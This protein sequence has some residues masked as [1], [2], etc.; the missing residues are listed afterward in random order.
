MLDK[1][2][3]SRLEKNYPGYLQSLIDEKEFT[4][5]EL[6]SGLKKPETWEMLEQ[7]VQCFLRH[8][9]K[10]GGYGWTVCWED[11]N[12]KKFGKQ[13][14]PVNIV[15]TSESDFLALVRKE[16][17]TIAFKEQLLALVAWNPEIRS[18]LS[19]RPAKVLELGADW[20]GICAVIDYL[21]K[22]ELHVHYLRSLPVPV[23]TK[24]I[25]RHQATI[26]PLV[27]H[28]HPGICKQASNNLEVA[29]GLRQKSFLFPVRWLDKS[30]Q[31][32]LLPDMEIIG[33]SQESLQ[34]M[35]WPVSEIWIV[36]NETTLYMLPPRPGAI[37]VCS[38][39]FALTGLAD[40]PMLHRASLY[41]WGDMDEAGYNMLSM[42]RAQY[43]HTRSILMDEQCF[44]LHEQEVERLTEKYK[45]TPP[46]HLTPAEVGAYN[47]LMPVQGRIEQ[48]K[49]RL[50]YILDIISSV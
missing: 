20:K 5:I 26:L 44:D 24:F 43:P 13:R 32:Q 14:W 40:I 47:R 28:L 12:S 19:A 49:L 31:Q 50:S 4:P 16:K 48:E 46:T 41:Y 15:V 29:L 30:L 38:K 35:H 8:E 37:A 11:W 23:H 25:E 17:E 33:L 34:R 45:K 21:H 2:Y 6:R 39:G 42:F 7:S 9:K 22:N 27:T 18:W 1:T 10:D 3:L 36:E